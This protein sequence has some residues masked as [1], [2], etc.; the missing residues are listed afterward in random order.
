MDFSLNKK[1]FKD[2]LNDWV[3]LYLYC[4]I[5]GEYKRPYLCTI[6]RGWQFETNDEKLIT[7]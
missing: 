2:I 1:E 6:E 5:W 4:G 7:P 3:Y